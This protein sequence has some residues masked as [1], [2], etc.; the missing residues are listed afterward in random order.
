M[1]EQDAI[2][3]FEFE[4]EFDYKKSHIKYTMGTVIT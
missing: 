1:I 4:F 2:K 3:F